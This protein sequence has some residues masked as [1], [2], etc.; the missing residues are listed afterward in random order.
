MKRLDDMKIPIGKCFAK[1][2]TEGFELAVIRGGKSFFRD[3]CGLFIFESNPG[4]DRTSFFAEIAALGFLIEA[5][6]VRNIEESLPLSLSEFNCATES[7]FLARS[8]R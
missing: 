2:D 5:L 3:R 7:N 1:I 6:P 8:L 4:S